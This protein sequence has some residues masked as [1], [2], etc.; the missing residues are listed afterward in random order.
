MRKTLILFFAVALLLAMLPA[1][2]ITNGTP[3]EGEHPQVGQL[4][5]YVPDAIDDRF[6]DPGSWFNCSGTLLSPTVVLTAGHCTWGVGLNG[7]ETTSTGGAGG[8]DVWLNFTEEPDYSSIPPSGDYIPDNNQGRYDDRVVWAAGDPNW[9]R[10][11]AYPHP[12]Y[13]DPAFF[14]Y[15]AGIVVLDEPVLLP[16]GFDYGQ[17]PDL[18]FL[19]QFATK[20]SSDT[21]F[22]P[23]GYGLREIKPFFEFG[24]TRY[25][26][27]VMLVSLRGTFG[28]PEGV[29]VVFSSNPG[30][31]ATGGT[32]FGDSGGPFFYEDTTTIVAV[33]SFGVNPNC[34]GT[35]GGYRIDQPDDLAFIN[36]FLDE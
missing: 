7:I 17:L 14:M 9:I 16:D 2:A 15:D 4:L 11:T 33:N 10:G 12:E 25:T 35:G 31:H 6:S 24:D 1:G 30:K 22:T 21:R 34:K 29:A 18:D 3:D 8:N 32:C 5:F 20:R 19:D 28:I 36:G 27:S 26:A 13:Y 23:V